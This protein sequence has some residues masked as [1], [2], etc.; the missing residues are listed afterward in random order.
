MRTAYGLYLAT[1]LLGVWLYY[2]WYVV[3]ENAP[4][5]E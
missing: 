4:V 1:I 5:F 2:I 3:I